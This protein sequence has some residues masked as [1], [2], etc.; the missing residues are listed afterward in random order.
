MNNRSQIGSSFSRSMRIFLRD[1]A[2][3]G[4]SI[5][6]PLFFLLVLPPAMFQDVPSQFMPLIKGYLVI[7]MITLLVM[8]T[9]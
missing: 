9:G 5:F 2:I 3:F 8:T 1:K 6:I 7:S 4:S